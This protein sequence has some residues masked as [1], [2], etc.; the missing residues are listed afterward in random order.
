MPAKPLTFIL[1]DES[2]NSYGFRVLTKGIDLTGF[3]K[4][5]VMF[6]NHQSWGTPI[7]YWD[8]IRVEGDK[9]LA[10]AVFDKDDAFAQSIKSKVEQKILRAASI[11]FD[12]IETSTEAP[13]VL[14]GQTRA[15]VTKSK[16]FES[17]IAGIPGNS[18]A[19][20]LR[21]DG[22]SITLNGNSAS[23]SEVLPLLTQQEVKE[24]IGEL[25]LEFGKAK[26]LIDADNE[27]LYK[28]LIQLDAKAVLSLFKQSK[29]VEY[30]SLREMLGSFS[31]VKEGAAKEDWDFDTWSRKDPQ[32]L[33]E[34]KRSDP[35]RYVLLAKNYQPSQ[36]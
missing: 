32:G 11:G 9:L 30:P 20:I 13:F 5:P 26:K 3:E 1:S 28:K 6:W 21:K 8:N 2:L 17:S 18:N 34:L 27:A 16:I 31:T 23:L 7:G 24:E 36:R 19:V 35:Q 10:E 15:T 29:P 4:N 12:V 22:K 14:P 33:L 25:I